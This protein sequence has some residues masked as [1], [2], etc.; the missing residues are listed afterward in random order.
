MRVGPDFFESPKRGRSSVKKKATVLS[1]VSLTLG[2][3][4]SV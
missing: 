2:S 1:T 4:V 3:L